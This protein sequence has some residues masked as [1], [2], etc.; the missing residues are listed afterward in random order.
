[1]EKKIIDVSKHNGDINWTKV[2]ADGIDGVII[3]A[4]Y[5]RLIKQKDPCFEKNYKG[6]MDAGLMVGAY[7]YS[8]ATTAAT[9]AK[10]ASTFLQAICDKKF[11]LPVYL[12]IEDK[13]QVK[14]SKEVCTDIVTAFG[15]IMEKAGYYFGVYSFDSFF[16]TN[17]DDS[18]GEKYSIWVARVENAKPT[19]VKKYD[20]WQYSW[21]GNI[22]G[23]L[24]NVDMDI[25]YK[26]FKSVMY[27]Y[28]FNN[29]KKAEKPVSETPEAPEATVTVLFTITAIRQNVPEEVADKM[30]EAL[31]SMGLTASKK[32]Q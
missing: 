31:N 32:R 8:Y 20:M 13:C 10:E 4:G 17:L 11:E 24:G 28:G 22:D 19:S 7:W 30:I 26:D 1:M 3:R 6:A 14:L 5:G 2:K 12:D 23:I 16:A 29:C 9:A 27:E 21:K 25:A 18:V 15:D